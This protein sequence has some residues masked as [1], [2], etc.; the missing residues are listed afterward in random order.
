MCS[1]FIAIEN[2]PYR[3]SMERAQ[4]RD[5]VLSF[6]AAAALLASVD[7]A[8]AKGPVT[9]TD[10]QLDKVTAGDS[11]SQ[12]AFLVSVSTAE[13]NKLLAFSNAAVGFL[14]GVPPSPITTP[15]SIGS[16]TTGVFT[17]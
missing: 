11:A 17:P 5:K 16:L 1:H 7:A 14:N 12:T 2:D 9:L 8:Y 10:G 15:A 3:L 13:L 4:M 6:V